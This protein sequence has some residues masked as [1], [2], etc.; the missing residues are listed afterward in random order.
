MSLQ[1]LNLLGNLHQELVL[2]V[3]DIGRIGS[4]AS[5]PG[6]LDRVPVFK[7]V[8]EGFIFPHPVLRTGEIGVQ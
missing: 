2:H 1:Y 4:P 7:E 3:R 8:E 6:K 5:P